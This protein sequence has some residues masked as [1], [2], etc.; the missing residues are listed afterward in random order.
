[1]KSESLMKPGNL[2]MAILQDQ[3][4]NRLLLMKRGKKNQKRSFLRYVV[5]GGIE[6]GTYKKGLFSKKNYAE[7][8]GA[9]AS[10]PR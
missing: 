5:A 4:W 2:A 7:K 1:M 3:L 6:N 9:G 8:G 10:Y